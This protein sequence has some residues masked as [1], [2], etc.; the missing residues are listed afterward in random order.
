M[1]KIPCFFSVHHLGSRHGLSIAFAQK[2]SCTLLRDLSE[3]VARDIQ[4]MGEDGQNKA[5]GVKGDAESDNFH[6]EVGATPHVLTRRLMLSFL[7]S[8][9]D[10]L[11][12]AGPVI[13]KGKMLLQEA[14]WQGLEWDQEVEDQTAKEWKM[15]VDIFKDLTS[16]KIPRCIKPSL[17]DDG[18]LELHH[19]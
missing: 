15:L 10:P 4:L 7:S 18:F 13:L 8:R 19:F 6:F 14:S 11:G 16:I 5:L 1:R 2:L 17:F 3:D 9:Y 12:L